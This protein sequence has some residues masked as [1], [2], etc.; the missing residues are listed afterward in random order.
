M[1]SL[2]KLEPNERAVIILRFFE[3]LKLS[4]IARVLEENESTV[5]SRLYR[6]LKV[7]KV[8]LDD[9]REA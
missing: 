2:K 6:A 4:D 9:F 5:K 8:E 7:L 1:D 3:D